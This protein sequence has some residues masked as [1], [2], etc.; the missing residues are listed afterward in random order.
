MFSRHC[1]SEGTPTDE[2]IVVYDTRLADE[3]QTPRNCKMRQSSLLNAT[4]RY[5]GFYGISWA[6]EKQTNSQSN[7][8]TSIRK[9]FMI[10]YDPSA[11]P[12][13]LLIT[14]TYATKLCFYCPS[15][16]TIHVGSSS[17]NVFKVTWNE[18]LLF[19]SPLLI[20]NL[21]FARPLYLSLSRSFCF[22]FASIKTFFYYVMF[23]CFLYCCCCCCYYNSFSSTTTRFC[24][25]LYV[26]Y[27]LAHLDC[28]TAKLQG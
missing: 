26:T 14:I 12:I 21:R 9:P 5:F 10:H 8:A 4:N 20:V 11:K 3:Y 24:V 15:I 2:I 28:K 6:I 7:C 1:S 16:Q 27:P 25:I 18:L 17:T 22:L 23:S 13:S 19:V